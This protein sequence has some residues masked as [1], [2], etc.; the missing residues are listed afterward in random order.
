MALITTY[1]DVRLNNGRSAE[2]EAD[3]EADLEEVLNAENDIGTVLEWL[4]EQDSEQDRALK[5]RAVADDR[6]LAGQVL[7]LLGPPRE[8]SSATEPSVRQGWARYLYKYH[9]AEL[10]LQM[11]EAAREE[12]Q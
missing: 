7:G 8:G 11:Y 9:R 6:R 12:G 3:V 1:I 2:I 4:G 10:L 5:A